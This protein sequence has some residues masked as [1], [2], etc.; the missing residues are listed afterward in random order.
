MK[1]TLII[2][3]I[4]AML[5]FTENTA[6]AAGLQTS[7]TAR[8]MKKEEL[9]AGRVIAINVEKEPFTIILP[10][11][12]TLKVE[13][14]NIQK[15]EDIGKKKKITP[16]HSNTTSKYKIYRFTFVDGSIVEG[17][18]STWPVFDIDTGPTGIQ[19]N[20]WL[21]HLSFIEAGGGMAAGVGSLR[22]G[23]K[24]EYSRDKN[25][26]RGIILSTNV[27]KD[28]F[29]II[30]PTGTIRRV[31]FRNIQQIEATGEKRKI[32]PCYSY[33]ASTYDLYRFTFINGNTVEGAVSTWPV[34]DVD[35][36]PTGLQK[37]ILLEYLEYIKAID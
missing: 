30:L 9:I 18:V 10:T 24:I 22:T 14:K 19:K 32:T 20:I 29:A 23:A 6:L 33:A 16:G 15:I 8:A 25:I 26:A 21:D 7:N 1:K 4:L 27:E 36:G 11:G 17:A 35:T 3:I 5:V 12:T 37:N 34:F 31:E 13:F 28:P 2:Y